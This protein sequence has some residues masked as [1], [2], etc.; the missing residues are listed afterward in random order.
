[1]PGLSELSRGQAAM[2][3]REE[4]IRPGGHCG[5]GEAEARG[6]GSIPEEWEQPAGSAWVC[7][8]EG[9]PD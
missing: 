3:R 1:M 7:G 4:M 8:G 2:G 9:I 6:E 5:D